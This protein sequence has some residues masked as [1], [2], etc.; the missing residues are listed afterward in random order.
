MRLTPVILLVAAF[1]AVGCSEVEGRSVPDL[2][3]PCGRVRDAPPA[4]KHV[5]WIWFENR[6]YDDA[7]QWRVATDV[8]TSGCGSFTDM[9]AVQHASLGNYIAATTGSPAGVDAG[10]AP[11]TCPIDRPS[12]FEQVGNSGR[13]WRS[14]AEGL[15]APCQ[16]RDI[17][18]YLVRHDPAA[19]LTRIR[20]DCDRWDVPL[21]ELADDLARDEL[22]TFA[23]IAPGAC[24]SGHDCDDAAAD[25]F[26]RTQLQ[27]IVDS[28]A[29]A[30]G[31]VALFVTFDEGDRAVAP[32]VDVNDPCPRTA[33]RGDCH[34]ATWVVAP[35][36]RAGTVV[37][38][39]FDHVAMLQ[40]TQRMLG[41][42]PRL[43]PPRPQVAR[44]GAQMGLL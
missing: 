10:C 33:Q 2:D 32:G 12:I 31:D 25:R 35:S 27:E 40:L 8:L 42:A 36:V 38:E 17:G 21:G 37:T 39:R 24:D 34:I 41:L 5:L 18:A 6:A 19:Y 4:W 11:E 14:Y 22:P 9:S 20:D 44:V 30:D 16:R 7:R 15:V 43:G 28:P 23:S 1:V 3:P 26:L 13:E 29:W